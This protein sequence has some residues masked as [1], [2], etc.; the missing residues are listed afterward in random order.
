MLVRHGD[1]A[2]Y[3]E[4]VIHGELSQHIAD[5]IARIKMGG[6]A[7][8]KSEMNFCLHCHTRLSSLSVAAG[9]ICE[10]ECQAWRAFQR[11]GVSSSSWMVEC[12]SLDSI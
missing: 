9:F 12:Y 7:G 10:G 4:T 3:E 8:V 6:G 11:H 2:V 5:L 1:P